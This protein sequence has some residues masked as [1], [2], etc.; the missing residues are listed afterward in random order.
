MESLAKL[1]LVSGTVGL[2]GAS[3]PAQPKLLYLKGT[4]QF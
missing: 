4:T 3:A 2:G 1:G